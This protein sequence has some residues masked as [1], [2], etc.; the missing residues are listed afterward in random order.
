MDCVQLTWCEMGFF[1]VSRIIVVYV[2][3]PFFAL[4]NYLDGWRRVYLVLFAS[5]TMAWHYIAYSR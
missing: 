5:I 4:S 3:N 2:C 1:F